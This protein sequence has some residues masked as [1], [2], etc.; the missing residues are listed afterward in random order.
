[1]AKKPTDPSAP[2]STSNTRSKKTPDAIYLHHVI[3][4]APTERGAEAISARYALDPID[5]ESVRDT[6][7]ES[8][9]AIV[10]SMQPHLVGISLKV[11]LDRI[12]GAMVG[13]AFKAADFHNDKVLDARELTAKLANEHRDED[14]DGVLGFDTQGQRARDFAAATGMRAYALLASATGA[15]EAFEQLTGDKW[16]PYQKE[17]PKNRSVS[18]QSAAEELAAFGE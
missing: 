15:V 14:R 13:G 7:I 5:F 9:T 4:L 6:T 11:T 18:R 16:K 12:V 2:K 8:L 17:Q 1:M 3:A 10:E